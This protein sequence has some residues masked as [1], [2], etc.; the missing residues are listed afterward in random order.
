MNKY[1]C[2]CEEAAF[3]LCVQCET[4]AMGKLRLDVAPKPDFWAVAYA[5]IL[6]VKENMKG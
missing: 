4:Q 6:N 2:V 5:I 3:M 1:A